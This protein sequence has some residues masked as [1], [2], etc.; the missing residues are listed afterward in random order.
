MLGIPRGGVVVA[1]EVARVLGLPLGIVATA[2][3]STPSSPEF[4]IGAV[5]ADGVVYPNPAVG[6]LAPSEVEAY[7]GPAR[8]KVAHTIELLGGAGSRPAP[9]PA[10]RCCWSTTGWPPG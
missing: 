4:A 5:S 2:K 6:L 10:G 8:A 3:V 9:S 1:A 7:A